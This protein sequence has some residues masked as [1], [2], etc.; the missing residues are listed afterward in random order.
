MTTT[1]GERP[2]IA[3]VIS[4]YPPC[5]GGTERV[6]QNIAE[7]L[8]ERHRVEV[9]TTDWGSAGS[10][11][12]EWVA[13][14]LVGRH[15][16]VR[17]AH[18]PLAPGLIL[19]LLT[20]PRSAVV[21]A[22][23]AQAFLP[24]MVRL[25]S[26]VR[27]RPFV[28]H[29]HLDVDASGRFGVLLPAYKRFALGPTLRRAAAVVAL[30]AEQAAFLVERY[31]VDPSRVRVIPNGVD[32]SFL[33]PAGEVAAERRDGPVR[34][35]FVGRLD[36]QKN[37]MRLLEALDHVQADVE[38]VVV[39]EGELRPKIEQHIRNAHLPNVR[40]VGAQTGPALL[41]WYRWADVF[42]L[43]SDKEGMPLVLLEAMASGLPVVATDVPGSRELVDGVGV[44]AP[45]RA[46]ALGAAIQAVASDPGLRSDLAARSA[47][48][49][50]RHSWRERIGLV[51]A[52]YET[53]RGKAGGT[54]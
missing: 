47:D 12:R 22:H 23:V 34:L 21:H 15:R 17:V 51:E 37:V 36:A 4:T 9:V 28:L 1:A 42:V 26:F 46:D 33:R 30:T 3:H 6:A 40:L 38:L 35:L 8:A 20:L 2:L 7:L 10:P 44:L 16:A 29:F 11:R 27:G 5:L 45:P 24:E 48:R 52:L 13:G 19:R 32:S 18:T 43:P 41:D 54:S 53:V 25:T 49:G 39:G 14:V 31:G 50:S